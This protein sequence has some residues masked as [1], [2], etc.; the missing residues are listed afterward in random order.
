MLQ[1]VAFY[2]GACSPQ[3]AVQESGKRLSQ[4]SVSPRDASCALMTP[5]PKMTCW[6]PLCGI[7]HKTS[8]GNPGG[9]NFELP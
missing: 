7:G 9:C 8:E 6:I 3:K 4:E 1:V 5:L 2:H